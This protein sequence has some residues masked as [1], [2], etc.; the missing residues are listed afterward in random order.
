M[1]SDLSSLHIALIGCGNMGRAILQGWLSLKKRPEI[2]VYDPSLSNDIVKS[3]SKESINIS[4]HHDILKKPVD[5][6][7]MAVKPQIMK[8]ACQTAGP[9]INDKTTIVSIAAGYTIENF[10]NIFGPRQP[11]IRTMPNTPAA[12]GH[13][14]IVGVCNNNVIA[15]HKSLTAELLR[16]LGVFEWTDDENLL[17]AVTAIS[18]SG[19]AYVFL[20]MEALRDAGISLGLP[21]NLATKLA[22]QTVKGGA[23]LAES[24]LEKSFETLRENVTSPGGT[25]EQALKILMKDDALKKL[26][27]NAAEQAFKRSVELS[28]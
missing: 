9:A 23:L 22:I 20:M 15:Q 7:I 16:P 24:D 12:V 1:M 10:E 19:P 6:V 17:N 18:G 25:T 28:D 13:G 11:I 21:E 4:T 27:N 5:I 2:T 14:A 26:I 3:F 8:Q